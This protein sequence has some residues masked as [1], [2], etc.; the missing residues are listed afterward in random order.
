MDATVSIH[1]VSVNLPP[2]ATRLVQSFVAAIPPY[3]SPITRYSC[4][5][6]ILR[7]FLRIISSSSA[8]DFVR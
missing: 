1:L 3:N 5:I 7:F 6:L 4:R 2:F 8:M